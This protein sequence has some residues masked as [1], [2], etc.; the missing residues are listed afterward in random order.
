MYAGSYENLSDLLRLLKPW[1]CCEAP[2]LCGASCQD[3]ALNDTLARAYHLVIAELSQQIVD[4]A[5]LLVIG[6]DVCE[7][8]KECTCG[9]AYIYGHEPYCGVKPI[10]SL[11]EW[12]LRGYALPPMD[13][14]GSAP[15]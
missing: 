15:R 14:K 12:L 5:D 3:S 2:S 7:L 10:C 9:Y 6:S 13:M 4:M 1:K 8:S 11:A